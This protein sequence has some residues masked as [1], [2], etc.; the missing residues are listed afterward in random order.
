MEKKD[1]DIINQLQRLEKGLSVITNASESIAIL[2]KEIE[3]NKILIQAAETKIAAKTS[4][5]NIKNDDLS[6]FKNTNNPS[7]NNFL[8][9]KLIYLIFNPED[10]IPSDDIKKEIPS[11]KNKCLN[12]SSE[13]IKRVMINRLDNVNWITPEFLNKVK[14]YR[15]YPYTDLK[16]ME[17][18]SGTCKIILDYFHNLVKY[19]ELYDKIDPSKKKS[20][21]PEEIYNP[22]KEILIEILTGT[23]RQLP[24]ENEDSKATLDKA[25]AEQKS[26]LAKLAMVE[27]IFGLL[28]SNNERWK[29]DV[30]RLKSE[31]NNVK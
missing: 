17:K 25:Q 6:S 29:K 9:F 24:K 3:S 8:I 18:I 12:R 1:G 4:I 16:E 20:Q 5:Q 31:Q 11:I 22:A 30:E 7:R 26:L 13:D 10:K 27:K 28:C 15:Q 2:K 21:H 14:M 23:K 19:K